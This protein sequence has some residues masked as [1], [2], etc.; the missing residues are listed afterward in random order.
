LQLQLAPEG[1]F[2]S[3]HFSRPNFLCLFERRS[4]LAIARMFSKLSFG[5]QRGGD[6]SPGA[7]SPS[8]RSQSASPTRSKGAYSQAPGSATPSRGSGTATAGR[9]GY[10][11]L[12]RDSDDDDE[13]AAGPFQSLKD[14][15]SWMTSGLTTAQDLDA[16]N[17]WEVDTGFDWRPVDEQTA[18]LL[19]QARNHNEKFAFKQKGGQ[20]LKF[21]LV[22]YT[23][24]NENTGAIRRI[25]C[26]SKTDRNKRPQ[27][28]VATVRMVLEKLYA[29]RAALLLLAGIVMIIVALVMNSS[30]NTETTFV[31][32]TLP[33]NTPP[34]VTPPPTL[35]PILES[36]PGEWQVCK[37][38]GNCGSA[39]KRAWKQLPSALAATV[40]DLSNAPGANAAAW[41]TVVN[42]WKASPPLFQGSP[43]P[44]VEVAN[45]VKKLLSEDP[46]STG[47][48]DVPWLDL[49]PPSAGKVIG[50]SQRQLAFIVANIIMGNTLDDDGNNG[51]TVALQRCGKDAS[52]TSYIYS[53]LS[54]LAIYSR[55]IPTQ[56]GTFLLGACPRDQDESWRDGLGSTLQH[57]TICRH[58]DDGSF[59]C[60][61]KDFMAGGVPNQALT[62]IA[63]GIVGGGAQLCNIAASQDESLVQFYSEVL[64]FAFFTGASNPDDAASSMLPVPFT[65]LGARRYMSDLNGQ[66]MSGSCGNIPGTNW[67]NQDI[68]SSTD[69]VSANVGGAGQNFAKSAFVAVASACA[70][71]NAGTCSQ[72]DLL[73]NMCDHQ[74]RSLDEDLGRWFQAFSPS[75]YEA[76]V[77]EAF[78]G[79]VKRIGTGPWGAGV[80]Y[81][82]SQ[83]YFL[84]VWLA[85]SLLGGMSL[86]YYIYNQFCENQ[87][88]Q[89]Y[90]LGDDGCSDCVVSGRLPGLPMKESS[91]G[92]TSVY[93]IS[94]QFSGQSAQQLYDRVKSVG[95]PPKQVFDL[96]AR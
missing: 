89:C 53:L 51:L 91:C 11:N 67:L 47:G 59:D 16:D 10:D 95:G 34:P 96:V 79:V 81:G 8:S 36:R 94:Q 92:P 9:G 88:N 7:G 33:P 31:I 26:R 15:F 30:S 90:V 87:G 4:R 86:D 19:N 24:R 83:Q 71:C 50:I 1:L 5:R 41:G 29:W 74:R 58:H 85:T 70:G 64:A 48:K 14:T 82:D 57:P 27:G 25:R 69:I 75:M 55:E 44:L 28:V 68:P 35:S 65:L 54:M 78:R 56:H 38:E 37:G 77:Q 62:D 66:S 49:R 39:F 84:T 18:Q 73:S 20:R 45:F 42:Q 72:S 22:N 12:S 93:S 60:G 40:G 21:D 46:F 61:L 63:G 32:P 6:D 52:K 43:I 13:E 80:W 23:E 2:G 3:S 76:S 17:L